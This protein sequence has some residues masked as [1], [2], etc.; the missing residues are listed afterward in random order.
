M[1]TVLMNMIMIY[2]RER[3]TLVTIQKPIDEGWE[4][5]TFPGGKAKTYESLYDSAVREA[6]EETGLDVFDLE[7]RGTV[8]WIVEDEE[9]Q[10]IGFLYYTEKFSGELIEECSEGRLQWMTPEEFNASKGMSDSM[11]EI[12]NVYKN[13]HFSEVQICYEGDKKTRITYF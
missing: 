9:Y 3:N 11:N 4:G 6:K 1:N 7:L 10:G 13:D 8:Q 5:L 12:M 2:D